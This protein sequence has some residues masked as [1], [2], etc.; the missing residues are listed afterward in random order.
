MNELPECTQRFRCKNCGHTKYAWRDL[1][2]T[3][4]GRWSV[5]GQCQNCFASVKLFWTTEQ[6]DRPILG[7]YT[8]PIF[9]GRGVRA[10]TERPYATVSDF[11]A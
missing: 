6:K 2:R 5:V 4:R 1:L 3:I 11:I 10:R 9:V 7:D 8:V